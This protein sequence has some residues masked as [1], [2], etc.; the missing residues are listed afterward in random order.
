MATP[1]DDWDPWSVEAVEWALWSSLVGVCDKCDVVKELPDWTGPPW[2]DDVQAWA[3]EMAPI[4][5][6]EG[7]SMADDGFNLLCPNCRPRESA[8]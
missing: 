3:K 5:Q 6:S 7:W 8:Q 2:N 4:L 1:E